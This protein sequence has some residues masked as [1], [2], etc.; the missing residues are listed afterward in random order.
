M[1]EELVSLKTF[2]LALNIGFKNYVCILDRWLNFSSRPTQSLLQK[3]FR[4]KHNIHL[5]VVYKKNDAYCVHTVTI[6]NK[7]ETIEKS[8]EFLNLNNTRYSSFESALNAGL[9]ESCKK[10]IK[11]KNV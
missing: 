6:V 1:T 11:Q 10:L 8:L 5:E 7:G 4:E 9:I 2:N 3:W